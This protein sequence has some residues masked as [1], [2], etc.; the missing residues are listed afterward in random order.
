MTHKEKVDHFVEYM[1]SKGVGTWDSAPPIFRLLWKLRFQ[2]PPPLF[3]NYKTWRL[4]YGIS[5]GLGYEILSLFPLFGTPRQFSIYS[6]I[7]EGVIVGGLFGY[8]MAMW[9]KHHNKKYDLP[10]WKDYPQETRV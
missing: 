9:Y 4:Y 5:F 3:I 7:I 10:E 1:K 8:F 2:I 6:F